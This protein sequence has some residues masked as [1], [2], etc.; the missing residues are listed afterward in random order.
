MS[1]DLMNN[2]T[3]MNN[4]K[5]ALLHFRGTHL[6]SSFLEPTGVS[7][8][9]QAACNLCQLPTQGSACVPTANFTMEMTD[10]VS[11][12]KVAGVPW[13]WPWMEYDAMGLTEYTTVQSGS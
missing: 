13:M 3:T 10:P 4:R 2:K 11:T 6:L 7:P 1:C 12:R 5:T 8:R 9:F